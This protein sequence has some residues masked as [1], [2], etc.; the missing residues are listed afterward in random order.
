MPAPALAASQFGMDMAM[1]AA[2]RDWPIFEVE[3][4]KF[5]K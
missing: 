1:F 5:A 4:G 3:Q 2:I